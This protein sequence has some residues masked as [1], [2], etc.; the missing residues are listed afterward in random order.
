[1]D[2]RTFL[3][4]SAMAATGALLDFSNLLAFN[5]QTAKIFELPTLPY[6]Y[7]ALEPHIDRQ[8]MEIHHTKHHQG[9]VTK[10]NEA[11][12]N[13]PVFEKF[14]LEDL[15]SK[16]SEKDTALRNNAGGHYNHSLFWTLL[17][18]AGKGK[19]QGKLATLIDKQFGSFDKFKEIFAKEALSRFGSGWVWLN[20][21][22][23]STLSIVS[24]PNQDNPL[25]T[26]IYK[27]FEGHK[28]L[29]CLDVWEHAYYL[30]YQNKRADY[31][32]AFWNLVNW[33]VV[34]KR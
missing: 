7:D 12:T 15:L 1:M 25:M 8:T 29:L 5:T 26:N 11:I 16:L 32:A 31:V 33:E 17:T 18:P 20:Q 21:A 24:T 9:Y 4:T 10:L 28:P 3:K 23:D 6:N 22:K 2:K 27:D 13:N 14:A 34:E 30:K 19:P